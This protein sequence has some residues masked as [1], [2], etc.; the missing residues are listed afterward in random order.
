MPSR[1]RGRGEDSSSGRPPA[2]PPPQRGSASIQSASA[3]DNDEA[4]DPADSRVGQETMTAVTDSF[5]AL[6]TRSDS[7]E[8]QKVDLSTTTPTRRP[9]TPAPYSSDASGGSD[10][11]GDAGA[12]EQ[13]VVDDGEYCPRRDDPSNLVPPCLCPR[14]IAFQYIHMH[15]HVHIHIRARLRQVNLTKR[16]STWSWSFRMA[17]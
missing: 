4:E 17:C 7:L 6:A 10:I 11:D 1:K 16:C 8:T 14:I 5:P 13:A 9:V 3:S 2:P 15:V 12:E